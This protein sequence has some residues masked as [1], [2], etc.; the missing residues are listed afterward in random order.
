MLYQFLME[1]YHWS[2]AE[3]SYFCWMCT[4]SIWIM[5][6][7]RV[8]V[9]GAQNLFPFSLLKSILREK[10]KTQLSGT[11]YFSLGCTLAIALFP[12]A[13]AITSIMWL[14]IG[15]MSAALIG[16]SIG[17]DMCVVKMGREGK[18]SV[19]G[20]VAMF[21]MCT[22]VGLVAFGEVYL[23]EY[24]VVIGA[25]VATLVELYEPFGINDNL[26]IPITSSLALQWGLSRIESC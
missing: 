1:N 23:R 2:Q 25:L 22:I 12:P 11:C 24:A 19:E 26:T 8:F 4:A 18:K 5:D 13:V 10:E 20:S 15:D 21:T 9:P 6:S 14:V 17:G 16:V 7:F 3:F